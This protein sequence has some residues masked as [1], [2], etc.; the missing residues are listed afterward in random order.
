MRE[1][2]DHFARFVDK[3]KQGPLVPKQKD[4]WSAGKAVFVESAAS[5]APLVRTQDGW[6]ED[7]ELL[8]NVYALVK[9]G[10]S[11]CRIITYEAVNAIAKLSSSGTMSFAFFLY[12]T[13]ISVS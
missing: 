11:P 13:I 5:S 6:T 12:L 7:A 8:E 10:S 9:M 4:S 1:V 2:F 3:Q